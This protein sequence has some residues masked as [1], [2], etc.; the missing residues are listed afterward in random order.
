VNEIEKA[1]ECFER[2]CASGICTEADK[3]ALATLREKQ[4]REKGDC[5]RCQN[6]KYN[7]ENSHYGL[8]MHTERQVTDDA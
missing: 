2:Q 4:E 8:P 1:I 5:N 3:I 7:F 6:G